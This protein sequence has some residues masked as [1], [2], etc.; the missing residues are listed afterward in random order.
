MSLQF[1]TYNY[2]KLN[3]LLDEDE[4]IYRV[5][6][7]MMGMKNLNRVVDTKYYLSSIY[8]YDD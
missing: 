5:S 2:D 4:N 3:K 6:N 1:N 7:N 8:S